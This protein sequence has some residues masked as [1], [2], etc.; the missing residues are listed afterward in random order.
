MGVQKKTRK[1]AQV[2]RV[3]GK[4]DDRLKANIA[5][6]EALQ[7]EK[8]DKRKTITG[9]LIKEAPQMPSQMFFNHNTSLVPPY[10]VLVDTN[11]ISHATQRKLSLD[12][13]MM[14]L[15]YAKCQPII[16]SCV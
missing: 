6:N 4:R 16:T 7:K 8:A 5:K 13:E 12:E 14:N 11:F 1:F 3:L 15:L 2:K 10:N 9:E